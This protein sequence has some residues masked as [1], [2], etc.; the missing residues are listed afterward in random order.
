MVGGGHKFFKQPMSLKGSRPSECVASVTPGQ[1][2][3]SK[4]GDDLL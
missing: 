2:L 3:D 4:A 1:Q